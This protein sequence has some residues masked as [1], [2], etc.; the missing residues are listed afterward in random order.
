[1]CALVAEGCG[2]AVV[3]P[4]AT[5]IARIFDLKSIALTD[6]SNLNMMAISPEPPFRTR[7]IDEI[8][9]DVEEIIRGNER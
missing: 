6:A 8:I 5:H 3:H 9:K 4:Y 1:M 7:I 2:V